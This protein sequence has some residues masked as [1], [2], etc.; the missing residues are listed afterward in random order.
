MVGM[1]RDHEWRR[2][3]PLC[4]FCR[5]PE[6]TSNNEEAVERL[7]RRGKLIDDAITVYALASFCRTGKMGLPQDVEKGFELL[8]RAAELGSFEVPSQYRICI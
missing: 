2:E 6:P 5:E 1:G 4:P 8:L 7:K 3:R